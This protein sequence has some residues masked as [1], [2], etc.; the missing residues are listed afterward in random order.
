MFYSAGVLNAGKK[1]ENIVTHEREYYN[2]LAKIALCCKYVRLTFKLV[3][4]VS[5]AKF[6]RDCINVG[7]VYTAWTH[8]QLITLIV[9]IY[10]Y[11]TF[12]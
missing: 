5:Y 11:F 7:I 6:S 2:E 3:V 1:M 12:L 9:L 10:C 4:L 8:F